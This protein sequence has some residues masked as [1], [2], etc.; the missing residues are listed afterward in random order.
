MGLSPEEF[1]NLTPE[2]LGAISKG[3]AE[4][5]RI[6]ERQAWERTRMLAAL[7]LQPYSKKKLKPE[8]VM[9]L[10]ETNNPPETQS[11][12]ISTPERMKE[13]RKRIDH[14]PLSGSSSLESSS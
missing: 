6:T 5:R 8:D 10:D 14:H 7:L 3:W 1:G 4:N 13:V 12:K 11:G 2:E 9:T